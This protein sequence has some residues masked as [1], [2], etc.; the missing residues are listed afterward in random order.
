MLKWKKNWNKVRCKVNCLT[1]N[2]D[3]LLGLQKFKNQVPR[4]A[5]GIRDTCTRIRKYKSRVLISTST[6]TWKPVLTLALQSTWTFIVLDNLCIIK[7]LDVYIEFSF[8]VVLLNISSP[9]IL[10]LHILNVCVITK[11]YQLFL[12]TEYIILY[13]SYI[14]MKTD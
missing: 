2:F 4:F 9:T 6:C 13:S 10:L 7:I 1:R 12:T 3:N 8:I 11:K 14:L 5:L